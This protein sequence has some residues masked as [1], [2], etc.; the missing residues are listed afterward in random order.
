M[1]LSTIVTTVAS[2]LLEQVIIEEG[3]GLIKKWY[4]SKKYKKALINT[5]YNTID[6]FEKKYPIDNKNMDKIPFYHSQILLEE[7]SK[8]VLFKNT[9][10]AITLKEKFKQDPN[11]IIPTDE[12]LKEFYSIFLKKVSEHEKLKKLFIKENYQQEIFNISEVI[13]KIYSIIGFLPS[14]KW[15]VEQCKKAIDDLGER[16][17]PELNFGLEIADV[18]ESLGRTEKFKKKVLKYFD[19]LLIKGK[20]VVSNHKVEKTIKNN[21]DNLQNKLNEI[22]NL[23]HGLNFSNNLAFPTE[24]ILELLN[25]AK[26]LSEQIEEYYYSKERKIQEKRKEYK[27]YHRY[28]YEISNIREFNNE[29]DNLINYFSGEE[30]KLTNNPY[31]LLYGEAGIGKSHLIADIVSKRIE[32]GYQ[33]IL[34]LG[35]HLNTEEDPRIQILHKLQIKVSFDEFLKTLNELAERQQKRIVIFIDAINE[36][37][38][39]YFWPDNIRSFI[40]EIKK[41]EWLGL[42]LTIRTSYKKII[43]PTEL[44]NKL[45]IIELKHLGFRG[46]EKEASKL[47]FSNYGIEYPN[48]PLLHPEFQNPLFLKLFCEGLKKNGLTR[49]SNEL[50]GIK[51]IIDLFISG[52]NNILSRPNKLDYPDK[53]NLVEKAIDTIIEYKISKKIKY[54]PYETAYELIEN[55]AKKYTTK[56]NVLEYLISEGLFSKNLFWIDQNKN[57]EGIYL[58]YERF[59]DHLIASYLIEK[60]DNIENEFKK[61]GKLFYLIKDERSIRLNKGLINAFAIQ[62]PEKINKELFEVIPHLKDTY[63]VV[64]TLIE[65]LLWRKTESITDKTKKYL[66]EYGLKY[67][68][69]YNLFWDTIISISTIPNHPFN[70]YWLN[71]LLF[72]FSMPDRDAWWTTYL[73]NKFY[74]EYAVKRLIDWAW[75]TDDKL[76]ISD[77]S[78]KLAS[79]T[80]AWFHTSTNRKLRDSDTKSMVNLLQDRINVLIDILKNF[81]NV[82]DPYV[83]ERLFAIAYGCALRTEQKEKLKELSE[84][85]YETIFKDKDEVYP[86]ALLRD[87]ARGII[88]YTHFLNYELSFDIEDVRPPYKSSF[89]ENLPSNQEIDDTYKL[90]YKS[91][92]FKDYYWAQ[93][94]ILNSMVTEHGRK[95]AMYGDFGRYV[96]QSAFRSFN[97]DANALSNLAVKWIFEKYGYDVEKHGIYDRNIRRSNRHDFKIERIGKKYQW[98]AFYEIFARVSD[99]FKKYSEWSFNKKEEPYQGPW[100]PY[101]RDIDPTILIKNTG[102]YDEENPKTFWWVK[103][104]YT[105]W[106]LPSE[107]WIKVDND[108]P[109]GDKLIQIIDENNEKWIVL[110]SYPEWAEPKKIGI[111]KWDYPHKRLWYQIRSYLIKKE[112]LKNIKNWM[113]KQNFMGR[114]MPENT[115]KYEIFSREYY[116]SPTYQYFLKEYYNGNEWK[117]IFDPKRSAKVG[118]VIVTTE[119]YLWEEEYDYSKEETIIYLKPSIK[120]YRGLNLKEA[121][122]EGAF[123][124]ENNKI[125]CFATNVNND[126]KPFL[127]IKKEPFIKFLKEN[128]LDIFWTILGEKEVIGGINTEN[129]IG[130]L[131]ISGVYYLNDENIEGKL[132]TKFIRGK[133]KWSKLYIWLKR[134]VWK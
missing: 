86:H 78:I 27:F 13:T 132:N 114:W 80:L 12:E 30:F 45:N 87:Y 93:N 103:E 10:D 110:E 33:S 97:V 98:I 79:I 82:N 15:F 106:E 123:L 104:N 48:T 59:E 118:K 67:N 60:F 130:R 64:E 99:N 96:F 24:K 57:E 37:K 109:T 127:L 112:D 47:F 62:L 5:F 75:N 101:I 53:I 52:V 3:Y 91:D 65:S 76:H 81:E 102:K 54:V 55:L 83:Y 17:T 88:E 120:I 7:F 16:Y 51:T 20:K 77:E 44:S 113:K 46:K 14:D 115:D 61:D 50:H 111:E 9:E 6:E 36:G 42:V 107:K 122:T 41:Y 58:A 56:K 73:G 126:S 35:Q 2:S 70:A 40:N 4:F 22:N 63:I 28:G 117:E 121:R 89:P 8:Y 19:Y 18:F 29:L 133:T 49:V 69:T 1:Y 119:T 23:V 90:D 129:Y 43:L 95:K 31:L 100:E 68:R 131:E 72:K 125:I 124:N 94:S 108:L 128:N 38:G 66:Q 34:I 74:D 32:S 92:D 84:Y 21:I 105:N 26:T 11:I 25:N 71:N 39:K 116:W 85:I 134:L